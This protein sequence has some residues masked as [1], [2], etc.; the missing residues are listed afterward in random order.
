MHTTKYTAIAPAACQ[1]SSFL[2][3]P[4]SALKAPKTYDLAPYRSWAK[5]VMIHN[6]IVDAKRAEE[7]AAAKSTWLPP[8][9]RN[10]AVKPI[11]PG[12]YTL[13]EFLA[14]A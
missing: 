11:K 2:D 8:K 5:D 12:V 10:K 6:R 4:R 14:D 13:D 3:V 9:R 1:E 7:E